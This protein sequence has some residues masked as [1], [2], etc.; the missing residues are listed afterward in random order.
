[1][2]ILCP[3]CPTTTPHRRCVASKAV[4]DPPHLAVMPLCY[5]TEELLRLRASPLVCKPEHLPPLEEWM[6]YD[7]HAHIPFSFLLTYSLVH[8]K[9]RN[10]GAFRSLGEGWMTPQIRA[11]SHAE[12][13]LPKNQA[14]VGSE[15][16][17]V[18]PR[19]TWSSISRTYHFRST[20]DSVCFCQLPECRQTSK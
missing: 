1:M 17:G 2:T 4:R 10:R 7:D 14:Q 8:P 5:S 12:D 19:L 18:L 9:I 3:A 15:T 6:G 11:S 20:D 13:P 16:P